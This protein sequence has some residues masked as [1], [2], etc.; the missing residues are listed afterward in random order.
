MVRISVDTCGIGVRDHGDVVGLFA[1]SISHWPTIC[2]VSMSN[3]GVLPEKD[4]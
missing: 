2:R 1:R 4:G 3:L